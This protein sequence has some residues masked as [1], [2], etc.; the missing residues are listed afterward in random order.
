MKRA[1]ITVSFGSLHS[2]MGI[3][4]I[5]EALMHSFPKWELHSA[6]A[7]QTILEKL[8]A[9]GKPVEGMQ[10]TLLR[11]R[12]ES[13]TQILGV[14]LLMTRGQTYASVRTAFSGY[15]VSSPLLDSCDDLRWMAQLLEK[16]SAK[17]GRPLLLMGHGSSCGSNAV[18]EHLAA[19][20]PQRT[21][22][23][24]LHGPLQFETLLPRLEQLPERE[25]CIMP[26]MLEC[27]GHVHM[28]LAGTQENSW[29][30][31][32]E[33]RGFNLQIRMNGLGSLK[34]VQQRFVEK[35]TE[36]CV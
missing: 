6:I 30:S 1:I 12:R 29:K 25:L 19:L 7:S 18:Y 16:I 4:G 21:Y 15:P 24:C 34:E 22:L 11:L 36:R 20:L 26:L 31:I 32:L 9:S 8:R 33:A 14:P 2:G 3:N 23:A 28:Q 27:G 10:E 35:L 5:E 17:D 13:Y